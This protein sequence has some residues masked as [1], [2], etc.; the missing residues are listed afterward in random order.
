[1]SKQD[2][3]AAI[4]SKVK[5]MLIRKSEPPMPIDDDHFHAGPFE[6]LSPIP[7]NA[8]EEKK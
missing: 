3:L 1:M 5:E 7:I 2:T 6:S 8:P 4:D